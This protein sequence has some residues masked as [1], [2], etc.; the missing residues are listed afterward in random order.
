M[1]R[2]LVLGE[3]LVD[4]VGGVA[5]PGGSP[6]NV[7]VGLGRLGVDVTLGTRIGAD[8]HGELIRA[9]LDDSSVQLAPHS[10]TSKPTSAALVTVSAEDGA[11]E[12]EFAIDWDL[13][14]VDTSGF[15]LVHAGSIG[16]Y[17]TP[18]RDAV[19]TAMHT[20]A[21][22]AVVT[23]D[24][25]IR[26]ALLG[27]HAAAVGRTEEL[28]SRSHVVKLSDEDAAWLYPDASITDVIRRVCALGPRLVA[29]T[30][31][32]DGYIATDGTE[33]WSRASDGPV[34]VV[35]T[36]GAGDAFMSGLLFGVVS[37]EATQ[38]I[39]HRELSSDD[40]TSLL[41]TALRAAEITVGRAGANPPRQLEL[42]HG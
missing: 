15:E 37:T 13:P 20:A 14:P 38:R 27:E 32:A 17:L 41:D 7:A 1:T 6:M 39:R 16:A 31:G 9:H 10:M 35:D 36:I 22:H 40:W 26:P 28:I 42:P 21:Q 23:F 34:Q 18:G 8:A 29:I 19:M 5:L 33:T 2:A 30:R 4:V 25:N 3:A 12:Y 24:P 11:A